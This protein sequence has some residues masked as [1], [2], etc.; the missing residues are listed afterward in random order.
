MS[1]WKKLLR[2]KGM[3]TWEKVVKIKGHVYLEEAVRIKGHVYL[4]EVVVC[5]EVFLLNL[6]LHLGMSSGG[7]QKIF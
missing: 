1:T 5:G 3:S 7:G 6:P 4:E 2:L